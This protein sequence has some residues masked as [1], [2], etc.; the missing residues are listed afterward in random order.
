MPV[1]RATMVSSASSQETGS[2]D[3]VFAQERRAW[4][5]RGV[6][7][8]VLAEALGAE[9]AAVDG[10]VRVAAGGDGLAVFDADEHAAADRAVAAGGLDPGV[11]HAASGDLAV[12]GVL[13][14]AVFLLRG[15]D[16]EARKR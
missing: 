16:A 9:L 15:V 2:S 14:V 1:M 3:A 6:E 4:R 5:G 7:D 11:G 12:H 8:V 10:V 13:R